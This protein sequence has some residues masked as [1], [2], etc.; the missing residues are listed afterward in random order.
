MVEELEAAEAEAAGAAGAAAVSGRLRVALPQT[1]ATKRL[2]TA[3]CRFRAEHPRVELELRLDDVPADL[4]RDGYD[5]S[6]RIVPALSSAVIARRIASMP[7]IVCASRAYLERRGVPQTPGDLAAHEC[8]PYSG[9]DPPDEWVFEHAGERVVQRV[10]GAVQTNN[11]ELLRALAVAGEGIVLQ[12]GFVVGEELASGNLLPVLEG[13]EPLRR[14]V[15][16]VY[17]SGR[18]V[19]AR[20]RAFTD[21]IAAEVALNGPRPRTA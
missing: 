15:F 5:L 12:P 6:I 16:A 20:A 8:L 7:V 1:F 4:I 10:R 2:D 9:N 13:Y 14:T 3:I 21:V 17:P 11:G 18:F 19:P